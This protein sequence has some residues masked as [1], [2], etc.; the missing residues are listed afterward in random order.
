MQDGY[1]LLQIKAVLVSIFLGCEEVDLLLSALVIECIYLREKLIDLLL[2]GSS[3]G[4]HF[5]QF[6]LQ[7]LNLVR[8]VAST[9]YRVSPGD[10]DILR[11]HLAGIKLYVI[12]DQELFTPLE[13]SLQV[14]YLLSQLGYLS[15]IGISI[16]FWSIFNISSTACIF[17]CV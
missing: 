2:L 7:L 6:M 13:V 12:L 8:P 3:F 4:L 17:K 9:T 16:N 11:T 14:E 5:F 1:C 10:R 15:R